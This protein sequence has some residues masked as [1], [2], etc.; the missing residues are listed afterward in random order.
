MEN[1]NKKPNWPKLAV[2]LAVFLVFAALSRF[3][4]PRPIVEVI[5]MAALVLLCANLITLLLGFSW[6]GVLL[7]FAFFELVRAVLLLRCG[8]REEHFVSQYIAA[9][10]VVLLCLLIV[11]FEAL[12]LQSV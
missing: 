11:E 4:W 5:A 2:Y 8:H 6:L 1:R 12:L 3:V 10:A 7:S 9:V